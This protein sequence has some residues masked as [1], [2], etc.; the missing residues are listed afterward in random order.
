MDQTFVMELGRNALASKNKLDKLSL[1]IEATKIV[2]SCL[3]Y[4]SRC[5]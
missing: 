5:V 4:T 1:L 2:N 3:L